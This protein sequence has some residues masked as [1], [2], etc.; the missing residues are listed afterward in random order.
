MRASCGTMRSTAGCNRSMVPTD[1][2][3]AATLGSGV[4]I[5][6]RRPDPDVVAGRIGERTVGA[7]DRDVETAGPGGRPA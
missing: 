4:D 1:G 5:E 7:E 6:R 2:V 3:L